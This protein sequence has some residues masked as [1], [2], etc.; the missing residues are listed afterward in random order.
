MGKTKE[1][2]RYQSVSL[3][4]P[5]IEEIKKHIK[6]RPE[7]RSVADFVREATRGKMHHERDID[8]TLA[9]LKKCNEKLKQ[10]KEPMKSTYKQLR[11]IPSLEDSKK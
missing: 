4:I 11:E 10:D 7:Y 6:D 1:G 5:F 3:A 9:E 2:A 8:L